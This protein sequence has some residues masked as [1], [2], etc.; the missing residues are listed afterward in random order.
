[1]RAQ[2]PGRAT[3]YARLKLAG[4]DDAP[5]QLA[6]F[7]DRATAQGHGLGRLTMPEMIEYSAVL[8]VHTLWLAAR[9]E[10]IGVGWVSIIDPVRVGSIL[11]VPPD[12][13]LVAY[14]CIDYPAREDDTPQLQRQG[15]ETRCEPASVLFRR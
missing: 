5:C 12:W 7:A 2:E 6:V 8:A 1:L 9:S 4:L 15:W 13:R 11:D 10:G 3:L 14:L